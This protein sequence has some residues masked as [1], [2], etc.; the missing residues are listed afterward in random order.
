[1]ENKKLNLTGKTP[2]QSLGARLFVEVRD[3][4][5][6]SKKDNVNRNKK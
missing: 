2:W 3:N 5:D 1:M 4:P 6:S